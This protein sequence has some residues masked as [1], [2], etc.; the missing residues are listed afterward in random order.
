[1]I[2]RLLL[3]VTVFLLVFGGANYALYY[4]AIRFFNISNPLFRAYFI[5]ALCVL[6]FS[7]FLSSFLIRLHGN[8]LTNIYYGISAY[9]IGLLSN[10]VAACVLMWI[11]FG[12]MKLI[13][14]ESYLF[15]T[16][17]VIFSLAFLFSVSMR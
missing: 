8:I 13:G 17:A 11:V 15:I 1:M 3:F 10:L 16:T 2:A 9:W 12:I 6:S 14:N 4:S 7:F 5:I